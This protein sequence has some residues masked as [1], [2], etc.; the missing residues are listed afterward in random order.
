MTQRHSVDIPRLSVATAADFL[1][2]YEQE[3][4]DSGAEGK[5]TEEL[6]ETIE[7]LDV[8]LSNRTKSR[9]ADEDGE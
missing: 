6:R 4:T 3:L 9:S 1:R 5:Y 7:R 2:E 8:A